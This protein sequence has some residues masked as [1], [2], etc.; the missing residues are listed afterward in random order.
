MF[1]AA[2]VW[3]GAIAAVVQLVEGKEVAEAEPQ[4]IDAQI[5]QTLEYNS[6]FSQLAMA[7]IPPVDSFESVADARLFL[8]KQLADM[9]RKRPGTMAPRLAAIPGGVAPK[10]E[11]C[12]RAAGVALA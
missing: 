6:S 2:D 4:D 9:S 12:M 3:N 5:E 7:V 10:I 11:A 1:D 8:A